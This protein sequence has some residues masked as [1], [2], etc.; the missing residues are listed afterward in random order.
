MP[1]AFDCACGK[2]FSVAD[3]YA[4]K[5]TK[6]P[7]CGGPL[8]VPTP[9]VPESSPEDEAFRLLAE[10][11]DKEPAEEPS[12]PVRRDPEPAAAAPPPTRPSPQPPAPSPQPKPRRL[13]KT[14]PADGDDSRSER[15]RIYISPAVMGGIGS[16]LLGAVLFFV[17]MANNRI[18]IFAPVIFFLGLITVI[19]GFLGHEEE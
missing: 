18:Y 6:C 4:G 5:R 7:A 15:P 16:M 11:G 12:T 3:E 1:I 8:T 19:R 17:G 2:P 9:A 10:D 14:R 13:H